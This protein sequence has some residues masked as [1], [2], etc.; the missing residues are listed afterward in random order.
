M[1]LIL[2]PEACLPARRNRKDRKNQHGTSDDNED[3]EDDDDDDTF[4]ND[5]YALKSHHASQK[6]INMLQ[7]W[8][9]QPGPSRILAALPRRADPTYAPARTSYTFAQDD[10][11]NLKA[12]QVVA[13]RVTECDDVWQL[14][15][16]PLME[17]NNKSSR[18]S[19]L[20]RTQ[21]HGIS[22][23]AWDLLKVLV[24]AW[25]TESETLVD[26]KKPRPVLHRQKADR[27][28]TRCSDNKQVL[29]YSPSLMAQFK[30]SALGGPPTDI[31][32]SME[33][34]FQPFK[35]VHLA[36]MKRAEHVGTA[37]RLLDLL[38]ALVSKDMVDKSAFQ[39]AFCEA[40]HQLKV[41]NLQ[42]LVSVG[43]NPF[44]TSLLLPLSDDP[45]L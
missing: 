30:L 26:G 8:I 23:S 45:R 20:N 19:I 36:N 31:T 29:Q 24:E 39:S 1:A 9:K 16:R 22:D 43:L 6:A 32:A 15:S 17:E 35:D 38:A 25:R 42:E 28:F 4:L 10:E 44:S 3:S 5:A 33:I 14:L 11:E 41:S 40:L 12:L 21:S 2:D 13:R 34:V 7:R 37:L 27:V 18:T